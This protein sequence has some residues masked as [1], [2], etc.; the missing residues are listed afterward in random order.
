MARRPVTSTAEL[1]PNKEGD[2][3]LRKSWQYK[4]TDMVIQWDMLLLHVH[5]DE[6][7]S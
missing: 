3:V 7:L 2:Q 4:Y 5:L 6:K 1:R